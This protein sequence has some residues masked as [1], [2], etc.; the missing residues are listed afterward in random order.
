MIY[1]VQ[2]SNGG[3]IKI[4]YTSK[5]ALQ[6]VQALQVAHPEKLTLLGCIVGEVP[7]E[8]ALHKKFAEYRLH[9]EWFA[10]NDAILS[11]LA[12]AEPTDPVAPEPPLPP[13]V[14]ELPPSVIAHRVRRPRPVVQDVATQ[15]LRQLTRKS[16]A[17]L[18]RPIRPRYL[19]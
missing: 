7:D 10:A 2:S 13:P 16:V 8:R 18:P 6:R 3:P 19:W 9:G 1:F 4:G 11:H 15:L 5:N 14:V 12:A 17:A